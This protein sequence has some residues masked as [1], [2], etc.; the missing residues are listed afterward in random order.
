MY[1]VPPVTDALSSTTRPLILRPSG[2]HQTSANSLASTSNNSLV[3][4]P[5]STAQAAQSGIPI[6]PLSV[7]SL[8]L[9]ASSTTAG[10]NSTGS[11]ATTPGASAALTTYTPP[12]LN[13]S[14]QPLNV[15]FNALASAGVDS[16]ITQNILAPETAAANGTFSIFVST[17]FDALA[18]NR[19]PSKPRRQMQHGPMRPMPPRQPV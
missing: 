18:A 11:T 7:N 17:L 6:D 8:V 13:T 16:A 15:V 9:P 14:T 12:P 2:T 5:S 4:P 1:A 3:L 10:V 19:P